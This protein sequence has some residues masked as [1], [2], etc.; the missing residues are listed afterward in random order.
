MLAGSSAG[1]VSDVVMKLEFGA[2]VDAE[3]PNA[4]HDSLLAPV[5]V[6]NDGGFKGQSGS[7]TRA[8]TT[9]SFVEPVTVVATMVTP[10]VLL[11]GGAEI[12]SCRVQR[13]VFAPEQDQLDEWIEMNR[14]KDDPAGRTSWIWTPRA[15]DGPL[16]VTV[17]S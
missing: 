4:P 2:P 6:Q 5:P 11:P 7:T 9:A 17:R 8:P 13:T 12:V 10:D 14:M 1:L 15:H 3:V 16:F